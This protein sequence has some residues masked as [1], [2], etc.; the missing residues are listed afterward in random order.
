[1]HIVIN[2][3]SDF[4]TFLD[5]QQSSQADPVGSVL[6]AT[7]KS[8]HPTTT[9]DGYDHTGM[10]YL[11]NPM[12]FSDPATNDQYLNNLPTLG[13]QAQGYQQHTQPS[14]YSTEDFGGHA[15][16]LSTSVLGEADER[17]ATAPT[18]R[19]SHLSFPPKPNERS[20]TLMTTS[21][22]ILSHQKLKKRT[23]NR[24]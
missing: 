23:S 20:T 18:F 16:T 9:M 7:P 11:G 14:S 4:L 24:L 6:I 17:L 13:I 19:A 1:M 22:T 10:P 21:S 15:F 3:S 5:I 8:Y 12:S 2:I